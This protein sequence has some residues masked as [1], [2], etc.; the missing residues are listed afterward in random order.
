MPLAPRCSTIATNQGDGDCPC[1]DEETDETMSLTEG[2]LE[3][4]ALSLTQGKTEHSLGRL[5]GR[6][7]A[8]IGKWN[9]EISDR[10]DTVMLHRSTRT[11]RS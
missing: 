11:C 8:A 5:P 10:H 7:T 3:C 1:K 6:A 4:T 2:D 9:A